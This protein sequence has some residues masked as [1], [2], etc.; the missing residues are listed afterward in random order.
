VLEWVREAGGGNVYRR[1]EKGMPGVAQIFRATTG[2]VVRPGQGGEV[3]GVAKRGIGKLKANSPGASVPSGLFHRPCQLV[4]QKEEF[5]VLR[6]AAV[7]L[8]KVAEVGL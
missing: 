2:E 6:Y 8:E 1:A 3:N 4:F 7:V 5:S